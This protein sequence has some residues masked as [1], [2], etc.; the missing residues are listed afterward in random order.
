MQKVRQYPFLHP[1]NTLLIIAIFLF[2]FCSV[3]MNLQQPANIHIYNLSKNKVC[4]ELSR[5]A[6]KSYGCLCLSKFYYFVIEIFTS[7]ILH[8]VHLYELRNAFTY[9]N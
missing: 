9:I 4:F 1:A 7:Y 8:M 3:F 6:F 5:S 2:L